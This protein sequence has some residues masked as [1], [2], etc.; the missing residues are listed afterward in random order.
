MLY[1]RRGGINGNCEG[2]GA[3]GGAGGAGAQLSA[4][5]S[6]FNSAIF[7]THSNYSLELTYKEDAFINFICNNA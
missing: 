6:S 4:V 5:T 1:V 7:S 2:C 3:R